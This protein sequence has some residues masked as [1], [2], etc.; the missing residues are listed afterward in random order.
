MAK[1][2]G[3]VN[4]GSRKN[5]FLV[6]NVFVQSLYYCGGFGDWAGGGGGTEECATHFFS[7]FCRGLYSNF[8]TR[9]LS[10]AR[11]TASGTISPVLRSPAV[12]RGGGG[13]GLFG[14]SYAG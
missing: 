5:S 12:F 2:N 14:P 7:H 4:L 9:L 13:G 3:R 1:P 8:L 11:E 6:R 10:P